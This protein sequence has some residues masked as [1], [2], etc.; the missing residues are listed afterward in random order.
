MPTMKDVAREAG[1]SL[2]T[3]SNVFNGLSTVSQKNRKKVLDAVEK[4]KF[5]PNTAA[6]SLKTN[7][8]KSFGLSIPSIGNPF[9]PE[10][11]RGVEDAANASGYS[12]FLC[13]NDR[14]LSKEKSYIR[15]LL[16]KNVDGIIL[17]KPKI[18]KEEMAGIREKCSVVVL[19]VDSALHK[20]EDVINVDNFNGVI[21]AMELLYAHQHRRIAFIAG[22]LESKSSLDRLDAYT[23]FLEQKNLPMDPS[24]IKSGDFDWQS[25]YR[26]AL[27]ALRAP[28]PPTAIFAANDLMAIGAMKAI[29]EM[30]LH[31]PEDIS[32]I[33]F[34]DID[35]AAL[36]TPQLTTV[37]QPKYEL[38]LRSVEMLIKRLNARGQEETQEGE[39]LLLPTE[40]MVRESVGAANGGKIRANGGLTS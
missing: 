6:R 9:Y 15:A 16:E 1:V 29:R 24:L 28:N 25:G 22:N 20:R 3:V 31:I 37:R 26:A 19:D 10:L 2:G 38:G 36:C 39:H 27:E 5:I 17:V 23:H 14:E 7:S 40:I 18:T 35:M 12:V 13:N 8:S 30:R 11:A 32:V 34:D 21:G 33:G 4:L